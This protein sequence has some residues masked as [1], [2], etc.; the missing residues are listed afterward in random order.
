M[1]AS[2][3]ETEEW[4]I[5]HHKPNFRRG[6]PNVQKRLREI[7]PNPDRLHFVTWGAHAAVNRFARIKN[8]ILAGILFLPEPAYE[9]TARATVGSKPADDVNPPA[10]LDKI[11]LGEHQHAILQALCRGAVRASR[12]SSCGDCEAWVIGSSQKGITKELLRKLFPG[13]K[14]TDWTPA[15][16]ER[17]KAQY[18]RAAEAIVGWFGE[19]PEVDAK[20][21]P[22]EA[23]KLT[24]I[25]DKSSFRKQVRQ[26]PEF[27]HLLTQVGITDGPGGFR[28]IF[29][30]TPARS[31]LA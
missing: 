9:A 3:P 22:A 11:V 14:V 1:I 25:K 18:E 19:R 4:L 29:G 30:T 23:M 31:T 6:M 2:K 5:V 21:T 8:V 28:R 10:N 26:H 12:G 7:V 17:S 15:G 27:L 16:K 24:G 20:L 13:A